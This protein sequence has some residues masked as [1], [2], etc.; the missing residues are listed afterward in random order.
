MTS[1]IRVGVVGVGWGSVAHAP[2]FSAVDDYEL[3]ALCG[4]DPE[5]L[6]K[7]AASAGVADTATDWRSF[8]RREDLDLISVATPVQTHHEI[9]MAAI[10]AGKHVL[11]EKPLALDPAQASEL[12]EA[13]QRSGV[14]AATCFENRWTPD[15]YAV[16]QAVRDGYLGDPYVVRLQ[17]TGGYWHPTRPP[18]SA[19]MYHVDTGGGYLAGM[20]SHDLDFV[21]TLLGTPAQVCAEV[22]TAVPR[23]RGPDGTEI[24]VDADDTSTLLLRWQ[25]GA[26]ATLSSTVVALFASA[27]DYEAF[28]SM[29]T[30]QAVVTAEGVQLRGGRVGDEG[31][32]PLAVSDRV[33]R[34]GVDLPRRKASPQIRAMALML[35][36][37]APAFRGQPTDVPTFSDGLQVE[38]IIQGARR[39]AA[40]EGWVDL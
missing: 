18:Q 30:L 36:D 12:V 10:A 33:L 28:G 22:H 5:R 15:R 20:V 14:V 35:E 7:A 9:V 24:E 2:A 13:V 17:Q 19:W 39:S 32:A 23:R 26:V 3:V 37:W 21:C 25:S 38:R 1:R 4:R 27:Y 29:G 16:W 31:L 6:A 8:V 11:C 40:G 34:S